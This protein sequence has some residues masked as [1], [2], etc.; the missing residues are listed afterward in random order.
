MFLHNLAYFLT[1]TIIR[2]GLVSY[3]CVTLAMSKAERL[4]Y[5]WGQKNPTQFK[6]YVMSITYVDKVVV[7]II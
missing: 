4:P 6:E 2:D 1:P 3:V 5:I 7:F